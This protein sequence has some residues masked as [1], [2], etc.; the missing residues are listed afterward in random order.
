MSRTW[1]AWNV[2]SNQE[3][4]SPGLVAHSAL[5]YGISASGKLTTIY[6]ANFKPRTSSMTSRFWSPSDPPASPRRLVRASVL[7][8]A[9]WDLRCWSR[10]V[11]GAVKL[12]QDLRQD[13]E[14]RPPCPTATSRQRAA[15]PH[16]P[17]ATGLARSVGQP[18]PLPG[19]A[20]LVACIYDRCPDVCRSSIGNLHTARSQL[21]PEAQRL[22]I[23]AISGPS[24]R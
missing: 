4:N 16:R 14:P 24:A 21:G 19:K 23:I 1:K 8:G 3:V 12:Q 18:E 6:D 7:L 11:V 5:V 9:G 2:G 10:A 22:Q 15:K 13:G 17:G 20:V